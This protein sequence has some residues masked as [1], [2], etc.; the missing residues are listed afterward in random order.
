MGLFGWYTHRLVLLQ[1]HAGWN[2]IAYNSALA[3]VLVG[4][5]L[6][7][8]ALGR[9]AWA[10]PGAA[11]SLFLGA[12]SFTEAMTGHALGIDQLFLHAWA[13]VPGHAPGLMAP[14]AALGYVLAGAATAAASRGPGGHRAAVVSSAGS[15]TF[16]LGTV[17][18]FGY[19]AG[20]PVA[21]GWGRW[22]AIAFP[23]AVG[24]VTAGAGLVGVAWWLL[25]PDG[26]RATWALVPVGAGAI[27][28][29]LLAWAVVAQF[30]GPGAR[31]GA[32]ATTG[33][34][35]VIVALVVGALSSIALAQFRRLRDQNAQLAWRATEA[36]LAAEVSHSLAE[37]TLD[38]HETMSDIAGCLAASIGDVCVI[39]LF[40]RDGPLVPVAVR[41]TDAR[42]EVAVRKAFP[43]VTLGRDA[44]MATRAVCT[45]ATVQACGGNAAVTAS[46][47]P[48]LAQLFR[49]TGT[50]SVS[51]TPMHCPGDAQIPRYGQVAGLVVM[52]R[53]D[54]AGYAD[55]EVRLL[56]DTAD[57]AGLA[58]AGARLHAAVDASERRFRAAIQTMLDGFGIFSAVRDADGVITDFRYEYVNTA[59]CE[60]HNM[61]REQLVGR[62]VG[63]VLPG[64]RAAGQMDQ[65]AQVVETG[66][67]WSRDRLVVEG[68]WGGT[69]PL[70]RAF[71]NHAVKLGD[72]IAVSF[73]EVT[74]ELREAEVRSRHA[75]RVEVL[76]ACSSAFLDIDDEVLVVERVASSVARA[77]EG[78]CEVF[79]SGPAGLWAAAACDVR[80]GARHGDG[81]D[82]GDGGRS[83]AGAAPGPCGPPLVDVDMVFSR[84]KRLV[85]CGASPGAASLEGATL[86]DERLVTAT[87]EWAERAGTKGLAYLPMRARDKVLGVLVAYRGPV[88]GGFDADE[89]DFLA[90][91][92]NRTA[93]A[94]DNNRLRVGQARTI[95]DLATSEERFRLAFEH[96]PTGLAV[97]SLGPAGAGKFRR[98][99]P[100]LCQLTGF[101][102]DRLSHMTFHD[103]V[104]PDDAVGLCVGLSG[105]S[106]G[107]ERRLRRCLRADGE[108]VW[109]RVT[110]TELPG[111]APQCLAQ[112]EDFTAQKS[113]EDDL[114]HLALHDQLT[115]LAN[116]RLAME[117]LRQSLKQVSR[118]GGAVAVLYLDLD[119]FKD[120]NDT[121][122]HEAGDET[123]HQVG[124]RLAG[125]VRAPDTAARLGG[126]E[127][128]LIC[129][130]TDEL[131]VPRIVERVMSALAAPVVI[132]DKLIEVTASIGVAT[133]RH[134]GTVSS[135]IV[136]QA[137]TAL[138]EA[139]R[140]GRNRWEAYSEGLHRKAHQRHALETDL[141]HAIDDDLF[142]LHYQ[143]IFDL[144]SG[145]VV[146]AEALLRLAHPTR[147]LLRP[148]SF[149]EVAEDSDLI[150]PIGNWVLDEA[151][152]QL[153]EWQP[154]PG[155]QLAVNVSGREA[156]SLAVTGRV[157]EATAQ[158]G[159]D[160]SQ[161]LLEMTEGVLIDGGDSV[162]GELD[163]LTKAGV[164]LAID[165]FGTGH[166]SL[167][168]LR[169]FPVDTLKIDRS[170]VAGLGANR[171]D[172]A[173]VEAVAALSHSLDL[174]TVAEGVETPDQLAALRAMGCHRAQGFLLGRPVPPED[175]GSLL[176]ISLLD[177]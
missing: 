149:I 129:G 22:T 165:D 90:D 50:Q 174:T 59:A 80:P 159:V 133:T 43:L 147:G 136:R 34:T 119:H 10:L 150:A 89:V 2:P 36:R 173:I 166:G 23:A 171:H 162:V 60:V 142:R 160:P 52:M 65:W 40:S 85:F 91:V 58:L 83:P 78:A 140:R 42:A 18:I 95:S 120:I 27:T 145:R 68:P 5:S 102:S 130:V 128:L 74:R 11:C 153:A 71:N 103:L 141:R 72:G 17:A 172:S 66:R 158:A 101:D 54:P 45:G 124:A 51:V 19:A 81:A 38:E 115:G 161:L 39:S 169:R 73:R 46:S 121:M 32:A 4:S 100:A 53:D 35:T 97:L 139:K 156:C 56:Q 118:S 44:D 108:I 21:Y 9:W 104:H 168:Y 123:L 25:R 26:G 126:D 33:G 146:G 110:M 8:M 67:P 82:R 117:Q 113:A 55:D 134:T 96:S 131:D 176:D 137:D 76:A 48:K 3:L 135:D 69:E 152:S 132:G 157:L 20:V 63:E 92:T 62:H 125:A 93:L 98:V 87:R 148:S 12:V 114:T 24:L 1:V 88:G 105:R 28:V 49:A 7:A 41:A 144:T 77:L 14:N 64:L 84:G 37:A 106:S 155:F 109:A 99:N 107:D 175:I 29:V 170:F 86:E 111:A 177:E 30:T 94:V 143:P 61:S 116:R 164:G 16:A 13:V 138:Y 31:G 15:A 163:R 151:C 79:L 70:A 6:L 75:R 127:F 154:V 167:S 57:R 122:G 112:I 47:R